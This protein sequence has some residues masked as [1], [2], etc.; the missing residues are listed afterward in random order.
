MPKRVTTDMQLDRL[1]GAPAIVLWL[2]QEVGC[3]VMGSRAGFDESAPRQMHAMSDWDIL[4]P[5]ALWDLA[6]GCLPLDKVTPTRRGGWRVRVEGQPDI[7]VFAG[8]VGEWLTKACV[9]VAWHPKSGT[10]IEKV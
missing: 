3:W 7:D 8:E 1:R 10:V 2:V 5:R 4:V 6:V 9:H